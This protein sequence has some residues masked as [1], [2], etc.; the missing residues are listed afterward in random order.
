LI[1]GLVAVAAVASIA[2]A[3]V[4]FAYTGTIYVRPMT[5]SPLVFSTGPNGNAQPYISFTGTN[6]GFTATL[7]ITNS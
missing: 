1:V 5:K 6:S 4:I 7:E 3:D 2:L